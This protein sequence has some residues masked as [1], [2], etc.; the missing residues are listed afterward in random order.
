MQRPQRLYP[1]LKS[2]LQRGFIETSGISEILSI[3][4]LD[5]ISRPK[6]S[7]GGERNRSLILNT[8]SGEKL[9]K[10]YTKN[11]GQS[12]IIQ[13]HSIL[14]YL[15]K[16]SFPAARLEAT[17]SG[18]TL[19]QK[20]K[21][22]YAL[23]SFVEKGFH[24]YDYI[25]TPKQARRY[26]AVAGK[27]LAFLHEKLKDFVPE[28]YNPDG[29]KSKTGERWRDNEW[30]LSKLKI[31]VD[32]TL[33][34]A[35]KKNKNKSPW[36]LQRASDFENTLRKTIA[37]IDAADL[38][39]QIIHKDY[40]PSNLLFRKNQPPVVLD[41]EI[42]RLDWRIVDIINGWGGF[43]QKRS[44]YHLN[45]MKCFLD[46]YQTNMPLTAD[47]FTLIPAVWKLLQ[48]RS[49][50]NYWYS[51]CTTG[52]KMSLIRACKSVKAF[53]WITANHEKVI[54][55]LNNDTHSNVKTNRYR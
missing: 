47:E 8:S 22:R 18:Q 29:F 26:I 4:G 13:E 12:T 38:P 25:T 52:N 43:C 46:A 5:L 10:K 33:L 19:V 11:I 49:C 6:H 14:K 24:S 35:E 31:C 20:D 30:F 40:G 44:G 28:G 55:N 45:K 51:Y 27:M 17:Q 21:D 41:F 32:K 15:A 50:I 2:Y 23:F 42:A 34:Q 53:D 16:I 9:L 3:Y 36:L 37:I 54:A 1:W 39:R 48:I 7:I